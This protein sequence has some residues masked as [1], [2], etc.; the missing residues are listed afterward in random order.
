MLFE[1]KCVYEVHSSQRYATMLIKYEQRSVHIIDRR[2][3]T[4]KITMQLYYLIITH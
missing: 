3:S 1:Q 2:I 4:N